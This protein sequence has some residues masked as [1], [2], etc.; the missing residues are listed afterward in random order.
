M[1]IKSKTSNGTS[2]ATPTQF[3]PFQEIPNVE[4]QILGEE[5]VLKQEQ[6]WVFLPGKGAPGIEKIFRRSI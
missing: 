5:A 1:R 3:S 4:A 6:P 2:Q